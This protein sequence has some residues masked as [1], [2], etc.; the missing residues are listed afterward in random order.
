MS[1]FVNVCRFTAASNGTVDFVVS[2]AVTGYQT[3]S[4][5]GAVDQQK[6]SYRAENTA[7]T[8]WEIGTGLYTSGSATLART[9]VIASSTGSKVNFTA[10]PQVALVELAADIGVLTNVRLAKTANYTF[11]NADK[12]VTI[13]LGGSAYFTLT[14]N[15]AS[16]Y[17]ANFVITVVNEDTARAKLISLNG[18]TSFRLW[19]GQTARIFNQNSAWLYDKPNRWKL[20]SAVTIFVDPSSGADSATTVDGMASGAAAYATV[21]FAYGQ[22]QTE[23][24]L[25]GQVV[26]CS[27]PAATITRTTAYSPTGPLVGQTSAN[28]FDIHGQGTSSTIL[29]TS[30]NG[31]YF[32]ECFNGARVQVSNMQLL[33]TG[34][35]GGALLV[36]EGQIWFKDIWFDIRS[37]SALDVAGPTSSIVYQGGNWT[38]IGGHTINIFAVSEDH[39][40]IYL[41]GSPGL[42]ISGSPAWTTAF[43][44]GDLGGMIEGTGFTIAL[45]GSP[46]GPR[47]NVGSM[48]IVFTG[49]SGGANFYPGN[50]VGTGATSSQGFYV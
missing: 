27:L 11:V 24:D 25:N 15:A 9:T 19:P 41:G 5:A 12:G 38:I 29:S 10:A 46:T 30:T 44:Q 21:D 31:A 49:G 4:S 37:N 17:D 50:S 16:G 6:Y 3:P 33:N 7:G 39:G 8:E 34:V 18:L 2:A 45:A 40:I 26:T 23:W 28:Q 36:A 1:A 48:G 14:G 43:V 22:V 13:A 42:T 20:P 32:V 47:Y 35:G